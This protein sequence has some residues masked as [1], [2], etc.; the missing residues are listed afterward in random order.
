[1]SRMSKGFAV[2]FM[3]IIAI[4][5]LSLMMVKPANAQTITNLPVPEFTV[6]YT[7]HSYNA[8]ATT[9][10]D[11]YT[12]Q[13]VENPAHH[14]VNRSIAFAIQ[15]QT[16]SRGFLHFIIAMK[17]HFSQSNWTNIYDGQAMNMYDVLVNSSFIFWTFSSSDLSGREVDRLYRGGVSFY[18]P[19]AGA[20]DFMIK[21]Q[22]W[23]E[24]MA[25]TSPQNPFGG[26]I[27][28]LFGESDWSNV[29][30]LTLPDGATSS[31]INTSPTPAPTPTVPE[32]SIWV[33]LPFF[34]SVLLIPVY[35]KYRRI[36]HE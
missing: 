17:G 34:V 32:F 8:P 23:G 4:S 31:S 21:A 26:S 24:V 29:Q 35:L 19:Y 12:G 3:L 14:V 15:N 27:T 30:T 6:K 10:V 1:M 22:T 7:D 13:S 9:S 5:S 33:V 11:P 16:V 20:V 2:F 18:L 36:S 25:T 28:T